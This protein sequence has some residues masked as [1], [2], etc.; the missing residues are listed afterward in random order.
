VKCCRSER[1]SEACDSHEGRVLARVVCAVTSVFA[2][3][4]RTKRACYSRTSHARADFIFLNNYQ[5]SIIF[6]FLSSRLVTRI[7]LFQ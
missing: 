2:N 1:A 4:A 5:I 3:L 6:Y 7:H